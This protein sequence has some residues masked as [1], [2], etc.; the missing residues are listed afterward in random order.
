[1]K[2][3]LHGY[4]LHEPVSSL[5]LTIQFTPP[6]ESL[7]CEFTIYSFKDIFLYLSN[8]TLSCLLKNTNSYIIYALFCI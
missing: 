1:M 5:S 7:Y 3:N 6:T 4:I 2:F 8:I